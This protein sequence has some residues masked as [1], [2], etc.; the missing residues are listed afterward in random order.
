ML[1]LCLCLSVCVC[2]CLCVSVCACLCLF[3]FFFFFF[4]CILSSFTYSSL[5]L[6]SSLSKFLS[7]LL[8]SS[9]CSLYFSFVFFLS[10]LTPLYPLPPRPHSPPPPP[11]PPSPLPPLTV[12]WRWDNS[13]YIVVTIVFSGSSHTYE[14]KSHMCFER[15][16]EG[17]CSVYFF[18]FVF[19]FVF[20]T[21]IIKDKDIFF[22][23]TF[24]K[25]SCW[26]DLFIYLFFL[27]FFFIVHWLEYIFLRCWLVKREGKGKGKVS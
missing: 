12:T 8:S 26:G 1:L 16:P 4:L 7:S 22:Y 21:V 10:W 14:I 11:P 27:F 24:S 25:M 23:W 2:L 20:R 9:S 6:S 18:V 3:F 15:V 5:F 13:S 19:V 17:N